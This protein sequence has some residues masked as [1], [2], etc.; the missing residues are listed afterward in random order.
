MGAL[1]SGQDA[2]VTATA[3]VRPYRAADAPA[4][5]D[6]CIRTAHNGR[7]SRPVYADPSVLPAIF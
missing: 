1:P 2:A 6:I 4:L 5:D 3:S 7:D